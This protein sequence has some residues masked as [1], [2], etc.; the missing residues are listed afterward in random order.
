VWLWLG[1]VW[2]AEAGEPASDVLREALQLHVQDEASLEGLLR[3]AEAAG[4]E[5][6]RRLQAVGPTDGLAEQLWLQMAHN[7]HEKARGKLAMDAERIRRAVLGYESFK[8]ESYVTSGV[9]PKRYLGYLDG[10]AD[11]AERE[12]RVMRTTRAAVEAANGWL[13]AQGRAVRLTEAEVATTFLAEGGALWLG[14]ERAFHPVMDVGLD[15]LALGH[16]DQPGLL[17]ALDAGTGSDLM[18]M[19]AWW[20]GLGPLP[21]PSALP[22]HERWL[23][24]NQGEEEGPGG[25]FPYLTRAMT[26]EETVVG[27]ALMYV[28]EKEIA[29]RKLLQGGH[30][31]IME[32][33]LDEQFVIASL[34]YNSGLLHDPARWAQIQSFSTGAWLHDRSQRN[35]ATRPELDLV[36]P[37]E[38][39]AEF[40]LTGIYRSQPTSWVAVYHVLQRYGGWEGLFR[41]TDTFLPDGRFAQIPE[42][43][44]ALPPPPPPLPPPPPPEPAPRSWGCR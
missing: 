12:I 5:V 23:R 14:E 29:E 38:Q 15:D 17:A 18:G 28:W 22:D 33:P 16:R 39:L 7:L 41:F 4:R 11:T 30:R 3:E 2:C 24:R 19:V 43:P 10:R 26:L 40:R 27:T 20:E 44:P 21:V 13:A 36:A 8:L 42:L 37:A 31:S 1:L 25:P 34:V 6:E 35:R 32:R 9:F